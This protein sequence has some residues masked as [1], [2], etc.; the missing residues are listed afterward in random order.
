MGAPDEVLELVKRYQRGREI[1]ESSAYLE[2][3]VRQEYIDPLFRALGWDVGNLLGWADQNKEVV[4]EPYVEVDGRQKAPDYAFRVGPEPKFFVEA[5][6][7]SIPVRV[8]SESAQQIRTY[9][10]NRSMPACALTNFGEF[11][12][13][14]TAVKPITGDK[15]SIAR[16]EYF[17]FLEYEERWEWLIE[18]FG[19]DSVWRG[20]LEEFA[21]SQPTRR[22]SEPVDVALLVQIEKWR[23]KLAIELVQ[24]NSDLNT[25]DLNSAVQLIIDRILFLRICE[26]RNVETYGGLRSAAKHRDIYGEL[27]R[28]FRHADARYNSG[29]FHFA[30][31]SSRSSFPDGL[32]PGLSIRD[33]V[34]GSLINDLYPP[35]SPFDFRYIGVEVLGS[36]YEQFLGKVISVGSDRKISIDEKP[37]IK[38][39]GGVV[40]TPQSVVRYISDATVGKVLSSSPEGVIKGRLGGKGSHPFRVLDPACGSGSFLLAV[41]QTLLDWYL[42]QYTADPNAHMRGRNPELRPTGPNSWQLTTSE[43]KRILLDHVFGVDIDPQAVE[44][45]K[46][47]LLL[48]CLEGETEATISQQLAFL[49][50][51][52]LPDLDA[53]IRCG[54]SLIGNDYVSVEPLIAEDGDRLAKINIFDWKTEFTAVFEGENPGFDVVVGNPPYV[55]LQDE[56]RDD[57]QLLYFKENYTVASYKIDTYHLFLERSLDLTREGGWMSMITPSNYLTNNYLAPL[58]KMLLNSSRVESITVIDGSVFPRRS[59]DCAVIVTRPKSESTNVIEM[60]H[61]ELNQLRNLAVSATGAIDPKI[62]RANDHTLFTGTSNAEV[63]EVLA[64]MER[65]GVTLG[66]VARVNFGKQLRNRKKF[67]EDVIEVPGSSDDV[68]EGY[69]ACLTGRDVNRWSVAWSGL[70]LLDDEKARMG[71]CWDPDIQNAKDKLITRQIGRYPTWGIDPDGLQC[72]NTVFMVAVNSEDLDPYYLLGVLNSFPVRAYWSDRFFDQRGTF[73]KIK[74]TYLKKLPIPSDPSPASQIEIANAAKSIIRLTLSLRTM[75]EGD[76]RLRLERAIAGH[77]QQLD[78][79]VASLYGLNTEQVDVL[80]VFER[81]PVRSADAE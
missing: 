69:A 78:S 77:E 51:R 37:E 8:D 43:R 4:V 48:K 71:G 60:L 46:L 3:S 54:N 16:V 1:Y 64:V 39:A 55:L 63:S 76:S 65:S 20:S 44:V 49:H 2:A 45:T 74:G 25:R 79:A 58:R 41:Y 75:S 13:Y 61:A 35:A 19:R 5:K 67:L 56:F 9:G 17:T 32:T 11:A 10:W 53:N 52:V 15:T 29:L 30:K 33:R 47:S 23:E 21:R 26:D 34:L 40:Y 36:A 22:G 72:L 27:L 57:L 24:Q 42:D 81:P 7:P 68:P 66:D 31:E 6:R 14:D 59:V 28:M 73:P 80:R 12:V 62:V 70:A 38:K 50:E 18:L